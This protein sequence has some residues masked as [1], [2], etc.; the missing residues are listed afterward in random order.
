MIVG[1][2][3]PLDEVAKDANERWWQYGEYTG[4]DCPKCNRTR[5]MECVDA[6]GNERVICEKCSWE[7]KRDD[8]CYEAI[9]R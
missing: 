8:Y 9:N 2:N 6:D 3:K 5:L 1:S 4:D 7:P